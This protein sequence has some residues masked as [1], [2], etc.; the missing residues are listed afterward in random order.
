MGAKYKLLDK[1]IPLFPKDKSTFID[2]F[3]GG[4]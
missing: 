4:I 3:T 1:L 2:L